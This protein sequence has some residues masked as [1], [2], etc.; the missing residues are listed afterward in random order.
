MERVPGAV[1]VNRRQAAVVAGVHRLQHVERL[2][3]THLAHDDAVGAHTKRVDHEVALAD[4][5]LA[6][7]VRWPRLE[8]DNMTLTHHELGGVLD[9]D[10]AL[11]S[12]DEAGEHVEQRRLACAG[13]REPC[14][15]RANEDRRP[16]TLRAGA[17]GDPETGDRD[18][19][20][21]RPVDQS[22]RP[23]G[24]LYRVFRVG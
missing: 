22:G 7:D 2:I 3:A 11:E 10:H 13:M 19:H 18:Q 23:G 6:L 5:A 8:S 14:R 12:R 9:G 16:G 24:A 4:R 17:T 15:H 21:Q 1:R 20:R